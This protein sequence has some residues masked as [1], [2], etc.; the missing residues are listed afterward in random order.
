M[1]GCSGLVRTWP[2]GPCSTIRPP[3][4]KTT[5][6]ATS[7]AKPISWVTMI[8]RGAAAGEVA[9][10]VEHLADELGVERAGGLVEQQDLRAQGE[11]AGDRDAL[12]LAAGQLARVVRRPCRSGPPARAA[13]R[14]LARGSLLSGPGRDRRLDDVLQR[15]QMREQVEVLEDEPD[16]G[17]LLQDLPL[18]QLVQLVAAPLVAD[19]LAVD[20]DSPRS[21]FSRW[22]IVRS[23]VDLPEP[24]GPEDR[25]DL[26]GLRP[27]GRC[28]LS[29]S[30]AA[31]G[32]VDVVDLDEAAGGLEAWAVMVLMSGL[33]RRASRRCRHRCTDA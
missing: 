2:G 30:S 7:R 28:P 25:D 15:G 10:D 29:T 16:L 11:R 21:T 3:S 12:L 4:M 33:L 5:R 13:Q 22:L 6:S 24:D 26:A 19:Q 27:S 18:A 20:G 23:S 8:E 32:L 1:R 14:E 31:V 9:D 17:A